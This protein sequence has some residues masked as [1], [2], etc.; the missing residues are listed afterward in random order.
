MMIDDSKEE[1][2]LKGARRELSSKLVTT[3]AESQSRTA[4]RDLE[5]L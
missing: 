1:V 3:E 2:G 4:W 5:Q